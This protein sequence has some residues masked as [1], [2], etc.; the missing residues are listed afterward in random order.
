LRLLLEYFGSAEIAWKASEINLARTGL[1]KRV[2]DE[3]ISQR[4]KLIPQQYS[5]SIRRRGIKMVTILDKDYPE[6]LKNI[7]DPPNVLFIKSR[8]ELSVIAKLT[9]RKIIAVVGTR[10]MTEYGQEVTA[11]LTHE[12]SLK[13]FTI[14]SG[15]ALGV[16]GVAHQEAINAGGKT[17][18]VLG[19]GVE[20]IY[21]REHT[22][23]YQS[24]FYHGGAILSEVAPDQIVG[25][26]IFP[27]RNRIV[28]GLSEAVLV[29]EGA[30]DSGSLITARMAL[31]QGREVFAVPGPINS[32]LAEGTN[33][34]LKQGARLVTSAQDILESLECG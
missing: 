33:Y 20:V 7:S 19:A 32:A 26:G 16:D 9:K 30:I 11:K 31:E 8:L 18:A 17:I 3:L 22:Q 24:I 34:L 28:S 29:T 14:V 1:S 10:K 6:R 13:G 21:P 5:E 15:M 23:L 2:L 12:L 25:R 4:R 27:A